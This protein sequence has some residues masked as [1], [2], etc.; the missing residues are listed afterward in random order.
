METFV[1]LLGSGFIGFL[2]GAAIGA[3]AWALITGAAWLKRWNRRR[4]VDA[5]II[6]QAKAAG[7]W[8]TNAGGRALELYAK[9][10]GIKRYP[11]ESD[12]HLR[13]RIKE[14]AELQWR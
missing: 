1:S 7:V 14:S 12:P 13:A 5:R 8:N 11:G 4:K 6:R 2:R 10:Y 9:E 3:A